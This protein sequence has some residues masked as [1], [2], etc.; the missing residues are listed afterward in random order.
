MSTETILTPADLDQLQACGISRE[1]ALR[2]IHDLRTGF[3]YLNILSSATLDRGIV[4]VERSEEA[5]YMQAWEEYLASPQ[6]H[7]CKMVPASGAA[8]RMFKSLFA[9][10][11]GDSE[12]PNKPDVQRFFDNITHFAFYERLGE[13]CLRTKWKSI[14]KLISQGDYKGV[15]E[16]LLT[17]KG[18]NYGALPKGLLLFHTY[19]MGSCTAAEEHLLEGALYARDSKG[20]VR[21]HFTVSP[22][23]RQAFDTLLSRAKDFYEDK[24]GVEYEITYSEQKPQTDTLAL[25][26]EGNP[27]RREDGTLLLR[28]GGHGALIANL[29]DLTADIVFIKNIDNVV[30]DH[31]KGAT[32]MYKKFLGGV[33]ISLRNRIHR[34]LHL[35]DRGKVSHA[36]L[37]E[38]RTFLADMLCIATPEECMQDDKALRDWVY[39]KLNRPIRVC[40]MVRNQGEPGGGPFVIHET[41]GSTSLQILESTQINTADEYQRSLLE[42]GTYFN[43]VDLVCALRDHQGKRYDLEK[44]VNAKTAFIA[45]KSQN[46]KELRALE[47]P[48]LWNGAMH[49]WNTLFVEV[50]IETFNPVKEV[51]DLL[52]AEHQPK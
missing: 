29:G 52:R 17:D 12:E 15:V 22:E 41:D 5:A 23:H 35:L 43:P 3:P 47:R 33:L 39:T 25:D 42:S 27:F 38:M 36:Q 32:I 31:L 9:F 11:E 8:S 16:T 20:K 48:G 24:Y 14:S 34:Y 13:A 46:G 26:G 51:N 19:P 28:P 40:G 18:L 50:P 7:V 2:Q 21:V 10:L 4:R 37:E 44:Y 49:E 45:H 6:A 1:E 30:P